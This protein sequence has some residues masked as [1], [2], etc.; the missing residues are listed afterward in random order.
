M[1]IVLGSWTDPWTI[2]NSDKTTEKQVNK[3]QFPLSPV[4][5]PEV[6]YWAEKIQVWAAAVGLDP[7]LA[8]TVMQIESCGDPGALSRAGAMGLF[9]VMPFHFAS[10][11]DPYDPDMN[12]MRGLDYLRKSLEQA[13]GD[14][15]LAMAGYNGGIGIIDLSEMVWAPETQRY[16]YWGSGIY[17]EASSGMGES[18]RLG[19]WM[20][21]SGASLCRQAHGRLGIN[22]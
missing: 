21:T 3:P 8:A 19:E 4:F 20:V 15:R 11:D 17:A 22:P 16:V 2:N 7:N 13:H 9:Q 18:M 5:S 10:G 12:A 14:A 1:F 6:Q